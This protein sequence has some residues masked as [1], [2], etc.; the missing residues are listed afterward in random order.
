MS[1]RNLVPIFSLGYNPPCANLLPVC[2][3]LCVLPCANFIISL[4]HV[5]HLA[6]SSRGDQTHTLALIHPYPLR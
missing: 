1:P 6:C 5:V 4:Q 3:I 2:S